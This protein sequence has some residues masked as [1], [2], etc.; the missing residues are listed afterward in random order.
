MIKEGT[1]ICFEGIDGSGKSTV[2]KRL[3]NLLRGKHKRVVYVEKR[4]PNISNLHVSNHMLALSEACWNY[5]NDASILEMGELHWLHLIAAWFQA[6]DNCKIK[7]LIASGHTVILD[8]WYY[9]FLARYSLKPSVDQRLLVDSFRH[10][11]KPSVTF[12]LD[13][14]PRV[15]ALRKKELKFTEV[16]NMDG[17]R[18][19]NVENFV[20][21]QDRVRGVLAEMAEKQNWVTISVG[22]Q[23]EAS[24]AR[25]VLSYL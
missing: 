25:N 24:T 13:V 16:G 18:G 5:P 11:T 10:L 12:F 17:L 4:S 23:D 9:K 1:L 3:F 14:D 19:I 15:A 2:S 7:P 6:L 20:R 22:H 21:Y 8:N